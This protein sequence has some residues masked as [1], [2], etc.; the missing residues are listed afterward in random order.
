[1]ELDKKDIEKVNILIAKIAKKYNI[2]IDNEELE[3]NH[4]ITTN[5]ND[6]YLAIEEFLEI[7]NTESKKE[8]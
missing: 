4:N 1:M 2:N 7:I 3:Y 8:V 5:L 6:I